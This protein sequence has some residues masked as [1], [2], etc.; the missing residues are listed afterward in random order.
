V[1]ALAA[2]LPPEYRR[3]RGRCVRVISRSAQSERSE[4]LA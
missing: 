4:D 1:S 2:K 3:A